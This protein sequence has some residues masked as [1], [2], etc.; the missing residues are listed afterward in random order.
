MLK[1]VVRGLCE[2]SI[3]RRSAHTPLHYPTPRYLCLTLPSDTVEP[4][5]PLGN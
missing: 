4:K 2:G 3:G 5:M 1:G